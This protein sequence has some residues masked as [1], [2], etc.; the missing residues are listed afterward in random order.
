MNIIGLD[1][2]TSA[3][4]WADS[5]GRCGLIKPSTKDVGRRLREIMDLLRPPFKALKPVDLCVIEGYSMGSK[6]RNN[7]AFRLPEL[8]GCVRMWLFDN[9][10]PYVEIPPTTLKK[11]ATGKGNA[12]KQEMI[13]AANESGA[14]DLDDDNVADAW[15]LMSVAEMFYQDPEVYPELE[16]YGWPNA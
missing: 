10:I 1:L 15:W 6:G 8:G 7:A 14:P 4:G 2:S 12:S 16:K 9:S 3:T 5:E 13:D 11:F